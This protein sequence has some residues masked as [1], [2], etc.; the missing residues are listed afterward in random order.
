M[1]VVVV[2]VHQRKNR[3]IF[4]FARFCSRPVGY[5]GLCIRKET[6]LTGKNSSWQESMACHIKRP[7]P[8]RV[9]WRSRGP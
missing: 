4:I 5:H 8:D 9:S 1:V 3:L 6:Q 7:W 2:V